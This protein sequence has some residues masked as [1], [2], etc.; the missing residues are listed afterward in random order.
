[1]SGFFS[2]H[3]LPGSSDEDEDE[4]GVGNT[5]FLKKKQESSGESRKF[6]KKMEVSDPRCILGDFLSGCLGLGK[7]KCNLMVPLGSESELDTR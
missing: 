4:D 2:S 6:H 7:K 1:M 5:T 3:F